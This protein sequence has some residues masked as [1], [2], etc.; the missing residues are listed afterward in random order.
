MQTN[1][2]NLIFINIYNPLK[3]VNQF[4]LFCIADI[5]VEQR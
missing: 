4:S 3:A 5:L 2:Y 1:N